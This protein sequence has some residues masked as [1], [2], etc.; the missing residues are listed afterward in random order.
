V[1]ALMVGALILASALRAQGGGEATDPQDFWDDL[2]SF[3]EEIAVEVVDLQVR[4]VDRKGRPVTG[5]TRDDF[6]LYV[7]GE[8]VEVDYFDA[9]GFGDG[10][11]DDASVSGPAADSPAEAAPSGPPRRW[12]VI[13]LDQIHLTTT[14]RKQLVRDMERF[15][16]ET[17]DPEVPVM[18]ATSA[19]GLQMVQGFTLD[20]GR[21][22]QVL[23]EEERAD[24]GGIH[25]RVARASAVREIRSIYDAN[26]GCNLDRPGGDPSVS[27]PCD[28]ALD[29]MISTVRIRA[30]QV[31][32]KVEDSL[33][34]LDTLVSALRGLPGSKTVLV[35]SDGLELIP[36]LD[37][38]RFV[39]DLCPQ[40][41]AELSTYA[42][43]GTDLLP[44]YQGVTAH[45]AASRVTFYSL[46][47]AGLQADGGVTA[48]RGTRLSERARIAN[49]QQSLYVLAD[50]TGGDAVLNANRF[51][52]ELVEIAEDMDAYYSLGFTPDHP[53]ADRV[54]Q[55]Y[56]DVEGKHHDVRY[57]QR[58]RHASTD[59]RIAD[60]ML[61]ALLFGVE[62]NPL[63]V[64]T[65]V[66]E[67]AA[68]EADGDS[69]ERAVAVRIRL[70][71]KH[72]TLNPEEG[73]AAGL[74]RLFLS[75]QKAA[76]DWQPVRHR[77]VPLRLL[78]GESEASAVRFVEVELELEP[79]EYLLALGVRDELGGDVSYLRETFGVQG[80]N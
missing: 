7:D 39:M 79:G 28:C 68:A 78:E 80:R 38:Y 67:R 74:V 23:A 34:A 58:Y 6:T 45:A 60:R 32:G 17:L 59:G 37:L 31:T 36:G 51:E 49:L 12:V 27:D 26:E 4:V 50:E 44:V 76:G 33:S 30:A 43:E 5:L 15:L 66:A 8:P 57:R 64:L 77:R 46:E 48:V 10:Q 53:G 18:V 62:Q 13:F 42:Q 54:H 73:G 9:V 20:R 56:V 24:P 25:E 35:A 69:D 21:V 65:E 71:L 22:L 70:P 55:I 75:V 63:N 47:T 72:L 52:D 41:E 40:Y 2:E 16:R 14:G 61:G 19:G 11:G 29:Q 1:L 3:A